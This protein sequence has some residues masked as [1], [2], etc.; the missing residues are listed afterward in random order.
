M[1]RQLISKRKHVFLEA[2]VLVLAI[3]FFFF[4]VG[5]LRQISQV[6]NAVLLACVARRRCQSSTTQTPSLPGAVRHG[7]TCTGTSCIQ[8]TAV[9][10]GWC[11]ISSL[12]LAPAIV[13]LNKSTIQ[14]PPSPEKRPST[15]PAGTARDLSPSSRQAIAVRT[16]AVRIYP[17]Q[18]VP[19]AGS[20]NVFTSMAE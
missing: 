13:W 2:A 17:Q 6:F 19:L 11:L 8:S 3:V 7:R 16:R 10:T 9:R 15:A 18:A 5:L 4:L 14:T 12:L 20:L 1:W